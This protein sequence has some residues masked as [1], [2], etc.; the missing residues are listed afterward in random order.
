MLRKFI[1]GVVIAL[2]VFLVFNEY[3]KF[4]IR[5][6]VT[7]IAD[8]YNITEVPQNTRYSRYVADAV[9]CRHLPIGTSEDEVTSFLETIGAD[10]TTRVELLLDGYGLDV[11][12]SG[13]LAG[14]EFDLLYLIFNEDGTLQ[15]KEYREISDSVP[16][17]CP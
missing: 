13:W 12:F 1:I 15:S 3:W 11:G 16:I 4:R 5:Q 14:T 9:I 8:T 7:T 17:E 10:Q 6:E 2:A